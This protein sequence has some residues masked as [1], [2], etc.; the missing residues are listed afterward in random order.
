MKLFSRLFRQAP[1][2]PP[3]PPPTAAERIA[4]LQTAT[5]DVVV[6]TALGNDDASLRVGA[7]RLLPD[8]NAL[9]V[10]AGLANPP[11]GAVAR[12][13]SPVRHA[14]Q[15]R[16]AQLIDEGSIDFAA[17]CRGREAQA[18]TLSVAAL[19]KDPA[20]L[21]QLLAGID[22]P[23]AL[24]TLAAEGPS[25][26]VRQAAAAKITDP[27]QLHELLPRLRGKDKAVYKLV[28]QRC[29]ALTAARRKAEEAVREST[30]LC[31]SLERHSQRT[32]DALYA[33][34]LQSLTARWR[35][36]AALA[37]PQLEQRGQQAL[38]RCREVIAAHERDVARQAA[39][40][41]ARQA[42]EQAARAE[43]E[44]EQQARQQA[45]AAQAAA[46]AT[47]SAAAAAAREAESEARAEQAAE[48]WA[49]ES[50][51]HREIG[52]LIR[53]CS[54]A[55]QRG[56]TRK[57]ARFRAGIEA[58]LQTATAA[59]PYL[60]R[61]LQQLDERLNELRQWKDYVVA[62]KRI[63]LIEEMEALV[64]SSEEPEALAEHIRSLQQ[65]WRTI[66]KG[67]AT[68]VSAEAERFQAAY[69][70]A[71]KPCQ[72]YFAAQ[73]AVRREHL[74]ARKQVL[75][76]LKAFEASLQAEQP[77]YPFILQV[78][79]EAPLEWRSHF[80]VDRDAGRA[81]EAEFHQSL[82]RLRAILHGW[83]ERNADEKRSLI[84]QARHLSTLEDT[85]QAIDGVKRLQGLWKETGPVTRDQQQA[86]WEEFRGLCDAVYQRRE[87]AYAQYSAGLEAA[88]AQAVA[89]CEQVE[90]ALSTL[91]EERASAHARVREWQAAFDALAELPRTEAR[92]LRDRFERAVARY[93]AEL[94]QLDQRDAESAESNLFE[95]GRRI[96]AYE[97]AV[98]QDA[99]ATEREALRSAAESFLAGV[100][101]WPKGG[102]Q[103]LKQA[104][105]RADS[106]S[107]AER[108]SRER[109][110]RTLCIRGEILTS[111]PTPPS[112]EA[113]RRDFEMRLLMEGLGQARQADDRD[114]EAMRL[115]WIAIGAV[116]PEVH[117]ELEHRFLRCLARR[118]ATSSQDSQFKN[119]DGRDR[120]PRRERDSGD[121]KPR[122]DARGRPE[123]GARR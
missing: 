105:A 15:E 65:E 76:R 13:P 24:A 36:L 16:V 100:A 52:S 94:A 99:P 120:E 117:D 115:E 67:I 91:A 47:A 39:E 5:A 53:L 75:E 27:A 25:S 54:S 20:R 33:A 81:V 43:R 116:A 109:A 73:A 58:A 30:A 85:T 96:R 98:L 83:H 97:R 88:K 107:A 57:A 93:D 72:A 90:Q 44:R 23:A 118:P 41:A 12:T 122:G 9:R 19:C 71:F 32:H 10:L 79:R 55:L 80:P 11:D 86:L 103:A 112:D 40:H 4:A 29:D 110:L 42:A 1:P 64:G 114:W 45:T 50:Q 101:R 17:L 60:V 63:E 59:P 78:L 102:L 92:G 46:D 14:A 28:K 119:H 84:A 6:D 104:L 51:A 77:D 62:P 89:L 49:A 69:H 108:E 22:D 26:R 111:T 7:V 74:E 87:Q 113:L 61:A 2:P 38:E 31:E 48:Q 37:D 8:G 121:R 18:D 68:D 66:N 95:A 3:P 21:G 70:A 106:V 123:G 35:A 56:D 34:T 82:D